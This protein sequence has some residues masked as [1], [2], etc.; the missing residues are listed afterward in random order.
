MSCTN[1]LRMEAGDEVTGPVPRARATSTG[2]SRDRRMRAG[3]SRL[4]R[5]GVTHRQ[6]CAMATAALEALEPGTPAPYADL[7]DIVRFML[8]RRH[9]VASTAQMTAA[10]DAVFAVREKQLTSATLAR[11]DAWVPPPSAPRFDSRV[12]RR[13]AGEFTPVAAIIPAWRCAHTPRCTG[14]I[15]CLRAHARRT[16]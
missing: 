2:L 16:T 1:E 12:S 9:L 15:A 10:L 6:L 5:Q 4:D 11:R 13:G 3:T 7:N 14:L 8:A